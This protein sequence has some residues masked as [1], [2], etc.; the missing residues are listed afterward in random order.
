MAFHI[1]GCSEHMFS[2]IESLPTI[3]ARRPS[4]QYSGT[5]N[6]P[7]ELDKEFSMARD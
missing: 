3:S 2:E 5:G 4:T 7:N 6:P 1:T